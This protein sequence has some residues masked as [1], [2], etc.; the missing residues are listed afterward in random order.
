MEKKNKIIAVGLIIYL[1]LNLL[2]NAYDAHLNPEQYYEDVKYGMR[3]D[4]EK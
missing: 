4:F 3:F 2:V 1:S